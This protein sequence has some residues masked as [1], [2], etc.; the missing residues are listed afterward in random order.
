MLLFAAAAII[1]GHT[2]TYDSH[3][4]LEPWAPLGEVL[5]RQMNWYLESPLDHGYPGFATLTFQDANR[6]PSRPD[7]IPAMQN[8]MGILSYVKY[9]RYKGRTNAR[10]LEFASGQADYLIDQALTLDSGKWPRFARSTG[11]GRAFPQAPDCGR[12]KD[13]PYEIEPDKGAMVAYALLL[14]YDETKAAKYLEN[15]LHHARVMAANMTPGDATHSPW[16]F[17]VD[18][19]SGEGRGD[20]SANMS[21]A[22]RLFDALASRGYEEF[23]GPREKLLRWILTIQIPDA[24]Q[25][26]VLWTQFH[27]DYDFAWNRNAWS[28]L[29]LARFL[30]ERQEAVDARWREDAKLLIDFVIGRFTSVR[31][32]VLVCG[33]QDDD[34]NPW[35]GVL[36]NF[37]GTLATYSA[38]TGSNEYKL[39]A[40]Q[41]LVLASYATAENGCPRDAIWKR[42]PG[43]WQED[44]H[45]DVIHNFVDA[46]VAFPE[47]A[48]LR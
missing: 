21:Y 26:A 47:W 10:V 41:A 39:V 43:G 22:L 24:K 20:V 34:K 46:L 4:L 28:P 1:A 30:C 23:A 6:Q 44:A 40:W 45:T 5:E 19:R 48:K 12:Q 33:E 32:G 31:Y 17:R 16:P 14:L 8:A 37:A 36:S 18:Y 25:E 3:G 35:G 7:S 29:N 38:A 27:E 11:V 9:Y 15:A 42:A 13:R 2:A